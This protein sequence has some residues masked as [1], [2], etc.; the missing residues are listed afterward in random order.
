[1]IKAIDIVDRRRKY[2]DKATFFVTTNENAQWTALFLFKGKLF[3]L[4]HLIS[5]CSTECEA[6]AE[7]SNQINPR[8]EI[9]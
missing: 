5:V 8:P 4:A 2:Q 1:M 6:K 9:A 7:L 3:V